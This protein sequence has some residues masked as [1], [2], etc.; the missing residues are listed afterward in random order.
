VTKAQ[1][2]YAVV[3]ALLGIVF[4]AL[5]LPEVLR[6]LHERPWDGKVDWWAARLWWDGIDAY[7]K[8]G[9][10]KIQSEGVGHPPTTSFYALPLALLPLSWMSPILGSIVLG[11]FFVEALLLGRELKGPVPWATAM[12]LLG[13]LV[14]AP[15]MLYHLGIA[16]M[17][18]LIGFL[19]FL[20][21]RALRRNQDL[22]AGLWLG[23]ACTMKLFPGLVVL[24]LVLMRRWRAVFTAAAVW[25]VVAIVMTS[26]FGLQSWSEFAASEPRIVDYWIGH[27]S[28]ASLQGVMLRIL[29]PACQGQSMSDPKASALAAGASL[30]LLGLFVW[31]S[32][33][34]LKKSGPKAS[35]GESIDL[36]FALFVLLAMM[37]NPFYFEHYNLLLLL[38]F[39]L[40]AAALRRASGA[41]L[42][43][44]ATV[45]LALGLL[46]AAAC[47]STPPNLARVLL[48]NA[49]RSERIHLRAHFLEFTT[50]AP[51]PLLMV[52]CALLLWWMTRRLP[53]RKA[54]ATP[55]L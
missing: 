1:R 34:I 25:L 45:G 31:L 9:L 15:F 41:G 44:W 7:S 4:F 11:L 47:L 14:N 32:W 28:N 39:A 29:H 43:R 38:P 2:N 3:A 52:V 24:L 10:D 50:G 54:A 42:P 48:F 19:F 40:A 51:T 53:R 5:G 18:G 13:I 12:L 8:V 46:G 49:R 21:W 27:A 33:P 26:R 35:P 17:S 30:L 20:G 36:P 22:W 55:P 16:Q 23:F 37:S 6:R